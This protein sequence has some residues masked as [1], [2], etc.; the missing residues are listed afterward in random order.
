MTN[1]GEIMKRYYVDYTGCS[2]WITNNSLPDISRLLEGE[3]YLNAISKDDIVRIVPDHREITERYVKS[4]PISQKLIDKINL[5][6]KGFY[7][8]GQKAIKTKIVDIV[9]QNLYQDSELMKKSFAEVLKYVFPLLKHKENN[10]SLTQFSNL[11]YRRK[12]S[13]KFY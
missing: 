10:W 5:K 6:V 12:N 4:P 3:E 7:D 2:G 8:Y 13:P 11:A 9:I 1:D